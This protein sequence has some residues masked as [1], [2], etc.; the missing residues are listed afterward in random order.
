MI[1]RAW[2]GA[3][4]ALAAGALLAP[5]ALHAQIGGGGPAPSGFSVAARGGYDL[6]L[7]SP[8]AGA[9]ARLG[10]FRLPFDVKVAGDFTFLDRLTERQLS[11]DLLY[12]LG[13][14]LALG[15]GPVYRNSIYDTD[16]L[17][18]PR[19]TRSGY[20]LVVAVGGL[21]GRGRLVSGLE[22]RWVRVDEFRPQTITAQMGLNLLRW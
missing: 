8:V 22:V 4:A 13:N 14:G 12:R 16:D 15:G 9:E 18:A 6:S 2:S 20:S 11:V 17:S 3:L 7:D 10:V 21:P 19:E 1:A 5:S